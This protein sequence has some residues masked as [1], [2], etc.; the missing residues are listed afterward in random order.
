MHVA[1][2]KNTSAG[3]ALLEALKVAM[4]DYWVDFI[5]RE[6]LTYVVELDVSM[7]KYKGP[8]LAKDDFFAIQKIGQ[9]ICVIHQIEH[10]D[11]DPKKDNPNL[12]ISYQDEHGHVTGQ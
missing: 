6:G 8:L 9:R 12:C 2:A 4:K 1:T 7:G 10:L 3:Q 5:E 11:T